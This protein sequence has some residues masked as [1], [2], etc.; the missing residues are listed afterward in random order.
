M[1]I[2]EQAA[3]PV[4]VLAD[5]DEAIT[6]NLASFLNRAGF[7]VHVAPDGLAALELAERLDPQLCVLDVL[8]PGT[9]GR[10]VLRPLRSHGRRLPVVLLTQVEESADRA[11]RERGRL[12]RQAI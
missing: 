12:S 4:V 1:V 9:D 7:T 8:M 3:R 6:S 10:K 2:G 5:D 11:R